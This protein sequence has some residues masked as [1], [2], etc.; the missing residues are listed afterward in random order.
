M[1]KVISNGKG[2]HGVD[3]QYGSTTT[4][5]DP[6]VHSFST[7]R[8]ASE[9]GRPTDPVISPLG[10]RGLY[11]AHLVDAGLEKRSQVLGPKRRSMLN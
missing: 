10:I 9:I 3:G 5:S 2:K 1:K 4:A 11:L 7:T 6:S 8:A